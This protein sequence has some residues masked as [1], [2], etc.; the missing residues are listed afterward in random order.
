MNTNTKKFVSNLYFV[1]KK[2][3]NVLWGPFHERPLVERVMTTSTW[4]VPYYQ[5]LY[6]AYPI[7]ERKDKL[8]LLLNDI[9]I[10]DTNWYQTKVIMRESFAGRDTLAWVEKNLETKSYLVVQQDVGKMA[11]AYVNDIVAFLD[12][13]N[14]ED[15]RIL[16]KYD[17]I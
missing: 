5:R 16:D 2:N 4:P 9:D 8:S 12:A 11:K 10:D 14:K 1:S 7:R 13:A 17:L 15:K 3:F 6:K